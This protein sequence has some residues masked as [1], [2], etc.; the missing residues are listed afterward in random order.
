MNEGPNIKGNPLYAFTILIVL[1]YFFGTFIIPIY[2]LAYFFNLIGVIGLLLSIGI[3]IAGFNLF[4]TYEENPLP[5]SEAIKLI[6]T[7]IFS[8]MR[9]P[10][11]TAFILFLFSMFLVFENVVY[12]LSF[13]GFSIWVHNFVVKIEEDYLQKKFNDEYSRYKLAVKRWIFF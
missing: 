7:G 4:K 13:V 5:Q 1:S 11:Y 2:P 9:N 10:I 3:F 12:F 8:Y 6:K